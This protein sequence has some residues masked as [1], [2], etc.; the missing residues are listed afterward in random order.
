MLTYL[1]DDD[2]ISLFLTE[3]TLRLGGFQAPILSFEEATVALAHL[4]PRLATEQPQIILLDLNMPV[5]NGWQFLDALLPHVPALQG[6][7]QIYLLT[8]SLS[9]ADTARA[10]SY[11]L[12]SGIIHKP[13]D[14]EEV[15]ALLAQRN[16]RFNK[17]LTVPT[18]NANEMTLRD[19]GIET[20]DQA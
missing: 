1:L 13:L 4:V 6:G 7:C 12:V 5:M 18:V 17:A 15:R 10:S 8:S 14:E 20:L 11:A 2:P 9:V 19:Y 3:Q 16:E